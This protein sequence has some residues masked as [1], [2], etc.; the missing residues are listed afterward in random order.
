ML[1]ENTYSFRIRRFYSIA[2]IDR[3]SLVLFTFKIQRFECFENTRV[4]H[5]LTHLYDPPLEKIIFLGS[6][7]S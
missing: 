1:E 6:I 2:I 4:S 7:N 5:I 3:I